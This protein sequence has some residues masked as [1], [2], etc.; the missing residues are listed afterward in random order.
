M[1]LDR[2]LAIG[3]IHLERVEGRVNNI[4][5]CNILNQSLIQFL[6]NTFGRLNYFF[7]NDNASIHVCKGAMVGVRLH[8]IKL[9]EWPSH[10]LDLNLIKMCGNVVHS[11]MIKSNSK[12]KTIFAQRFKKQSTTNE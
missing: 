5:Y 4:A 8:K 7:Q 3:I 9:L 11:F 10:S 1:V 12:T 6:D 2:V